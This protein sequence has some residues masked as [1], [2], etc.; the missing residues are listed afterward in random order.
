[1]TKTCSLFGKSYVLRFTSHLQTCC[2]LRKVVAESTECFYFL[3]QNL[4]MCTFYRSKANLFCSRSPNSRVWRDSRVILSNKKSVFAQHA[5]TFTCFKTGLNGGVQKCNI[6]FEP[7]LRQFCKKKF[8]VF[9]SRFTVALKV[10]SRSLCQMTEMREYM[11]AVMTKHWS[12]VCTFLIL[13]WTKINQAH[14]LCNLFERSVGKCPL[15]HVH[16]CSNETS[17]MRRMNG[18]FLKRV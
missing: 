9:V 16:M 18:F 12:V 7:V 6:A 15:I 3:Q 8:H 2:R 5:A 11:K 17:T 13:H 1:M 14:V 10:C 4:Y